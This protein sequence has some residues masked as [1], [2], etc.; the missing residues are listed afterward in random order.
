VGWGYAYALLDV[1]III[2]V[3]GGVKCTCMPLELHA[4]CT[5]IRACLKQPAPRWIKPNKSRNQARSKR[6]LKLT[7]GIC[8]YMD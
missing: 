8:I 4:R 5:C 3:V 6:T 2:D 1:V 7:P